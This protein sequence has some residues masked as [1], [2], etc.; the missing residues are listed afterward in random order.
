M[1]KDQ[2]FDCRMNDPTRT[3][4]ARFLSLEMT[5]KSAGFTLLSIGENHQFASRIGAVPSTGKPVL[6]V[7]TQYA[8]PKRWKN[9][10]GVA[11]QQDSHV[12][13]HEFDQ[14]AGD[15]S[16]PFDIGSAKVSS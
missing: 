1:R 3:V 16:H 9:L 14:R 4:A 10:V 7:D 5:C 13:A 8:F 11:I 12:A 6:Q 15:G 2:A